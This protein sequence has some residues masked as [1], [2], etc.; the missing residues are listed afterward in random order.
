MNLNDS[1]TSGEDDEVLPL[2]FRTTMLHDEGRVVIQAK[3]LTSKDD[4]DGAKSLRE[5]TANVKV[6]DMSNLNTFLEAVH[7][8]PFKEEEGAVNLDPGIEIDEEFAKIT[9][10]CTEGAFINNQLN[11]PKRD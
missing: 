2:D 11:A 8:E 9:L 3:P 6:S 4:I 7:Q 1:S 10:P 5:K